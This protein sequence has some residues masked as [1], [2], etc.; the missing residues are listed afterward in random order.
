MFIALEQHKIAMEM[1]A[2]DCCALKHQ[3]FYDMVK[4]D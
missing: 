3:V 2:I 1:C 4:G